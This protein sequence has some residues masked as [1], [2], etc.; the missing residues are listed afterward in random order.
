MLVAGYAD[1]Q[2]M[3][4]LN[5]QTKLIHLDH[6]IGFAF[7]HRAY[8]GF[9]QRTMAGYRKDVSLFLAPNETAAEF[10]RKGTPHVPC[11]VVGTPK[12]DKYVFSQPASGMK[13]NRV[14]ITFHWAQRDFPVPEASTALPIYKNF[15][16]LLPGDRKRLD[17]VGHA[18][19]RE[20]G[21][22]EAVYRSEGVRVF[23]P[24]LENILDNGGVFIADATS[25]QYEAIAA[26]LS[27]VFLNHPKWD[28][29]A[30]YGTRFWKYTDCGLHVW[31]PKQLLDTVRETMDS[32]GMFLEER[33][34]AR[35]ELYPFIGGSAKRAM[36]VIEEFVMHGTFSLM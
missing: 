7:P 1:I 2:L 23:D 27:V 6:G 29:E 9:D 5:S 18:H 30:N 19:P 36:M 26:G 11:V 15:I 3:R 16:R 8:A 33:A 35:R 10:I 34:K 25:S 13:M 28:E 32:P 22:M 12:M 21:K 4:I 17:L 20:R 24:N 31:D 14:G